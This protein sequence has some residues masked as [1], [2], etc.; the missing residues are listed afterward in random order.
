MIYAKGI[1]LLSVGAVAKKTILGHVSCVGVVWLIIHILP[2]GIMSIPTPPKF[3]LP[4]WHCV[5]ARILKCPHVIP[6]AF[7]RPHPSPVVCTFIR[8]TVHS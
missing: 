7:V 2:S 3:G 1:A 8:S 4:I 5:L 6:D